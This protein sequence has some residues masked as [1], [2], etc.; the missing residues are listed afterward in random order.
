MST[1][2]T[3][4]TLFEKKF[5]RSPSHVVR[6]PGRV[7]L[8]GEHTDYNEG[9]VLP[10]AIDFAMTIAASMKEPTGE[11]ND[12]EVYSQEYDDV[13]SFDLKNLDKH[14]TKNWSNYLRAVLKMFQNDGYTIPSFQAVLT[15]DVPQ[16]AG[17]SSSAAFEVAVATLMREFLQIDI[18]DT[19]L[20]L[21]CQRA[22]NEFIG[23]K[24]GIMD[25]FISVLGKSNSALLID[26]RSLDYKIVPL[27]L[28][29]HGFS[30]VITNSG[31]R[32]GLVDS[33][34]NE[35]RTSC[36]QGTIEIARL[37]KR[38]DIKSLRDVDL[39]AFNS[40][41]P[42]LS[43]VLAKRCRHIVT[44]N[45]RVLEAVHALETDDLF[46]F[47]RLMNESHQSLKVDFEVSCSQI[48]SLVAAAQSHA[49]VLGSRITGAG[50]GGCTVTLIRTDAVESYRSTV[51]SDYEH[52]TGCNAEVYVCAA[53]SGAML[54]DS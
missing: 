4:V 15:G 31:V 21:L 36:E 8:I 47:G 33:A 1:S 5:N 48:D 7:N 39:I 9:F 20:A 10:V 2:L 42:N 3:A 27:N 54:I 22:E 44:E 12:V 41:Q 38:E 37:L 51:I 35:R 32:R 50:F 29:P 26:C 45:A 16:G 25:Q 11:T 40:A 49:G 6:A 18:S 30:L 17:L 53:S 19:K 28:A 14:E 13:D 43:E 52:K 24:C 34:Y 46:T 23:M